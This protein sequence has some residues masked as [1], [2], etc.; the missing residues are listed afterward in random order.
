MADA[1]L[2]ERFERRKADLKRERASFDAHY[3]ELAEFIQP[4]R[5]RFFTQDRNR[6]GDRYQA[7]INSVGTQAHRVA[8][9]GLLAGSMS[10]AAKWFQLETLD[11]DLNKYQPVRQWFYVAREVL[12][13]IFALSNNYQASATTLGELILFGTGA[14]I[15]VD[16]FEDVAR[17]YPLTVGSYWIG[18]DD[19]Q[20]VDT[21]VR[22]WE[23]TT[24]QMVKKWGLKNVS[25]SVKDAYDLG[26]YDAWWPVTHIIEP[27][28]EYNE[29]KKLAKYK[30]FRSCYYEAGCADKDRLLNDSG[31][32][33]F[34]AYAPR[35]DTTGE[36]IYGTDCPGMVAFGDVKGLQIEERRKAQAIDLMV[37]PLM[38]GPPS[39]KN[40]PIDN[41]PGGLTIYDGSGGAGQKLEPLYQVQPRLQE[42]RLDIQ[43]VEER[44]NRA[45]YVHLF[46]AISDMQGIQPRN[47]VE[48]HKREQERLLELGPALEHLHAEYLAKKV[49]RTFEQAAK[50]GILP[51]APPELQGRTVNT[52]FISTLAMAQRSIAAGA[53][54]RLATFVAGLVPFAPGAVQKFNVDEAVEN[55]AEVIGAPPTLIVPDEQVAAQRQAAARQQALAQT[56]ETADTMAG[57]AQ[58]GATAAASLGATPGSGDTLLSRMTDAVR[59]RA[60]PNIFTR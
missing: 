14:E 41:L 25:R 29:D 37:R 11:S 38:G 32:D 5:G 20:S 53:I 2:R 52:K 44:I 24:A 49:A 34:P 9:S 18:Q 8:R 46:R 35:W 54:E 40:V 27:N 59:N 43:A 21:L 23:M 55:Y 45:F 47:Q 22:E 16:D 39:V 10:P 26:N 1:T 4:R 57:A 56:A 17:F 28:I 3:K 30:R 12:L 36:D 6:G 33:S 19:R 50:A 15:H 13:T 48:L 60:A 7:I 42:M 58:K 51:P 31:F